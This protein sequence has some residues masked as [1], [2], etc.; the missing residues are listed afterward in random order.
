MY[1]PLHGDRNR[2]ASLEVDKGMWFCHACGAGGPVEQLVDLSDTWEPP[3]SSRG[4]V[5]GKAAA[6]REAGELPNREYIEAWVETLISQEPPED[7]QLSYM[8]DERGI[9]R[10]TLARF[11]IGWDSRR[12]AFTIPV[13]G[14]SGALVGVRFYNPYPS[15]GRERKMWQITGSR[16]TL[17]PHSTL[18]SGPEEIIIC[19]GEWDAIIANQ[20][21]FPA[22]TRT[23]SADT[24][25][26]E[27][28]RHF[29]GK[30]VY[31]CHDMDVK[32]QRAN[33]R[34]AEELK[35]IAEVRVVRLPYPV[36]DKGG[37]D[38]TDF[39]EDHPK[40][41]KTVLRSLLAD[42]PLYGEREPEPEESEPALVEV[43]SLIKGEHFDEVLTARVTIRGM[44][45][46]TW[47]APG[48]LVFRCTRDAGSKCED[49]PMLAQGRAVETIEPTDPRNLL[50]IDKPRLT[51]LK[52]LAKA[53]AFDYGIPDGKC[54]K[55]RLEE[56][57][58]ET[59]VSR[60]IAQQAIDSGASTFRPDRNLVITAVGDYT[61]TP[62]NSTA[63]ISGRVTVNPYRGKSEFLAGEV[64]PVAVRT[65]EFE[66]TPEDVA[67]LRTFA[68][69]PGQTPLEHLQSMAESMASV[70][71]IH[72]RRDLTAAMDLVFHSALAFDFRRKRIE[73]GWLELLVV[74]DTRT[75]KSETARQLSQHYGAGSFVSCESATIVGIMGGLDRVSGDRMYVSWG[76]LPMNDRRLVIL[77]EVKGLSTDEISKLSEVRSSGIVNIQKV[78]HESALARTRAIWI[79]NPREG[80]TIT[81]LHGIDAIRPL[82]G[83]SEDVA[84]FDMAVIV[85]DDVS[86]AEMYQLPEGQPEYTAEDCQDLIRWVWS[87][88]PEQVVWEEGAER[89]VVRAASKL[90]ERYTEE[91]P[92]IRADQHHKLAR[93]TVA[94]AARL[95]STDDGQR[96]VVTK[97]HARDAARFLDGLYADAGYLRKS[98]DEREL[99]T[100]ARG[101]MPE[102][103]KALKRSADQYAGLTHFL[104][105]VNEFRAQDLVQVTG[106]DLDMANNFTSVLYNYGMLKRGEYG[107][108]KPTPE[109][110]T[111]LKEVP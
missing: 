4:R 102:A 67:R 106:M 56:T 44:A 108:H 22:V 8:E 111:L 35:D 61:N 105:G 80:D 55:L 92:L 66:P 12:Q 21:G 23:A 19:E 32:G 69:A 79:S 49:C 45:D 11:E 59:P 81:H 60:F 38:I 58:T 83:A 96:I 99:R 37:K 100:R 87:R 70:T 86:T 46:E 24:W 28:N 3:P 1:C 14:S 101:S 39:F 17:Y 62:T 76:A 68:P 41:G 110:H 91:P 73:R 89:A 63:R 95:F 53:F 97:E 71:G 109:F 104:R 6:G 88:K 31:V 103:R 16:V 20:F 13:Y 98:E 107:V 75:G 29:E 10:R 74:G 52:E 54:S 42:A 78:R 43:D 7:P 48:E 15:G 93:L 27:W 47:W 5:N 65:D 72:G 50:F 94:L 18:A 84:R 33:E 77:D 34:V 64:Q 36:R 26:S 40:D 90:R 82:I 51:V 25:R 2:S 9:W 30:R 57:E 85:R